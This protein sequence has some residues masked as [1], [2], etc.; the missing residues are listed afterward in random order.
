MSLLLFIGALLFFLYP[1]ISGKKVS[2]IDNYLLF[3]LYFDA[4]EVFAGGQEA[5][6]SYF[7]NF[8]ILVFSLY[9]FVY[10]VKRI[11]KYHKRIFFATIFFLLT[12]LFFPIFRGANINQTVRIFSI[13]YVSLIILPIS[14]HY[15]SRKGNIVNLLRSG[16]Y[17]I[18]SWVLIVLLFT[19]LKI[20]VTAEHMGSESFGGSIF[21]FG[22]MGQRGALTYIS[23]ALL[24][25]PLIFKYLSYIK[26]IEIFAGSGFLLTIMSVALK[27]FS[28]VTVILGL[29]NYFLKSSLGLKLKIGIFSGTA[30]IVLLLYFTTNLK[31]ITLQSYEKRGTESKF[32][33]EAIEND[34]RIYEPLY[35]LQYVFEGS[36][37]EIF[38]GTKSEGIIDINSEMH[39]VSARRIHN[40]YAAIILSSGL[41]GLF[42]YLYIFFVLY[43]MTLRLKQKLLKRNI[44]V[45]EY[46]IVFQNLVLIFIVA[47]MVG[48]HIHITYRGMVLLFAGGISGYFYKLLN[49]NII[50]T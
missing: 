16:Y 23:F 21:Y 49:Q 8:L 25:V 46:W 47:G 20:D 12:I 14:F 32:K 6:F 42:A 1:V 29:I 17:F 45:N 13:N 40:A 9:Y 36:A 41:L 2:F 3:C 11:S 44:N 39:T 15:Y 43:R 48:G 33:V 5:L 7:Q 50:K 35:A 38:F 10:H 22:N 37:I 26:K 27:R 30:V 34:L 19:L 28:F 31:E 18:L 24:L 4:M